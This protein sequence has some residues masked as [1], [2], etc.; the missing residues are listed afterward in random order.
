MYTF[1]Q[2]NH[3]ITAFCPAPG[4]VLMAETPMQTRGI[5]GCCCVFETV[6]GKY[7]ALLCALKKFN[8]GGC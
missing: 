3:E 4:W 2:E 8:L 5:V 7:V 1:V 6:G